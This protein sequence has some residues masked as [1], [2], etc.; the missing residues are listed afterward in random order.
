[1]DDLPPSPKWPPITFLF[2]YEEETVTGTG[3]LW[4]HHEHTVNN[5]LELVDILLRQRTEDRDGLLLL[6]HV[7][8]VANR[9][10]YALAYRLE[11]DDYMSFHTEYLHDYDYLDNLAQQLWDEAVKRLERVTKNRK[12]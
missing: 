8:I 5:A 2:W 3:N 1:M 11:G 6:C 4:Y 10:H 7:S 12:R 9:Q